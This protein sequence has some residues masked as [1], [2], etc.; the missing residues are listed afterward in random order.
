[1]LGF[2]RAGEYRAPGGSSRRTVFMRHEG[3]NVCLAIR[4]SARPGTLQL[5]FK[6]PQRPSASRTEPGGPERKYPPMCMI[7]VVQRGQSSWR[8]RKGILFTTA[9]DGLGVITW[10]DGY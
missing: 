6:P 5:L 4:A 1:M 2:E 8:T 10:P 7:A 9:G 3:L